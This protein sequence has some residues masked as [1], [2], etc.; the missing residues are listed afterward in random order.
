M[1]WWSRLRPGDGA[2]LEARL[3][4]P[5][6]PQRDVLRARIVL[7]AAQDRSTRSIT[8]E[9]GTMPRMLSLWRGW[10]AREGLAGLAGRPRAGP[11][12]KYGAHL[13]QPLPQH[14]QRPM[15]HFLRRLQR[16]HEIAEIVDQGVKLKSNRDNRST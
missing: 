16:P 6:T 11:K 10:Y 14:G 4:A 9:L 5:R 2:V 12:R 3:R 7:L 8:R 13:D 15:L 1:L